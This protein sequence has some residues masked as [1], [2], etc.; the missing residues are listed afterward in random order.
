M[1]DW[2]KLFQEGGAELWGAAKAGQSPNAQRFLDWL[3]EDRQGEMQWLKR[4]PEKRT[5]PRLVLEGCQS[6]LVGAWPTGR[7]LGPI[8]EGHGRMAAYV[9]EADYHDTLGASLKNI[10][11]ALAEA[12]PNEKFLPYV[13]TGPILERDWAT[14]AGLGW[15]GKNTL[16]IHPKAGSFFLL[17][18]LL[19]TLELQPT[20]P[21]Q[22]SHCGTCTRCLDACPTQA[23]DPEKGLDARLCLSTWNIEHKGPFNEKTPPPDQ[24]KNWLYGCDICQD[25]CPFNRKTEPATGPKDFELEQV[26]S[27][28]AQA[29]KHLRRGQQALQRNANWLMGL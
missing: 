4:N 14:A 13:D 10:A 5:D 1:A 24:W 21:Y 29:P 20:G 7:H 12:H 22:G 26:Q 15:I 27:G 16:L 2:Q 8:P 6:I 18:V 9:G 3:Y 17:G 19:T 25:V 23:L 11:T 28:E